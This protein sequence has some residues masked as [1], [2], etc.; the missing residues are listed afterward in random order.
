MKVYSTKQPDPPTH[1]I[2]QIP[3]LYARFP[4]MCDPLRNLVFAGFISLGGD[5]TFVTREGV[6]GCLSS[7]DPN[8]LLTTVEYFLDLLSYH[9]YY[10]YC[11][12]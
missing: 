8:I 10:D 7:N 12:A 11:T 3:L 2:E 5:S 1:K 6:S 4:C 9:C